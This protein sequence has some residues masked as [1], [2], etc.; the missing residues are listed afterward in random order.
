[1]ACLDTLKKSLQQTGQEEEE[2][3][4][5]VVEK[6]LLSGL[7]SEKPDSLCDGAARWHQLTCALSALRRRCASHVR[8][9]LG[10]TTKLCRE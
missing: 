2:L 3:D 6:V 4:D 5:S 9:W 8:L 7:D 10:L 1:M